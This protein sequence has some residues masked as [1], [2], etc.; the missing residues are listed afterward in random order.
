MI[1][2]P[3]TSTTSSNHTKQSFSPNSIAWGKQGEGDTLKRAQ[4]EAWTA[5]FTSQLE[6]FDYEIT[7]IEGTIPEGLRGSTLF[8]NGPSRFERGHQ[9]VSHYLD[10][11]GY[12]AKFAFSPEGRA[13]FKSRFVKTAE[14]QVEAQKNDL[15]FRTT[16]GN[17]KANTFWTHALDLYLKNPANTHVVPWGDRL[18]ALYEAGA[19]Y[20]LDPHTLETVG[21]ED[22]TGGVCSDPLPTSRVDGLMRRSQGQQAM[23]AHPHV[24]PVRDRIV[25]WTWG[26]SVQLHQPNSLIIE[27]TEYSPNWQPLSRTTHKM[28]GAAV[29]PH[30]FALTPNYY[31]FFENALSL[32]IWPYLLGQKA[33]AD[34]LTL[35]PRATKVHLIPRPD[36]TMADRAPLV[37]ETAQWFSIHQACAW[38]NDDGSVKVYSSGW[39]ATKG[40]F[41]TS[42]AGTAP[43]F[44]DIAPTFLWQTLIEPDSETLTHQLAPGVENCCIAHPHTSPNTETQPSRYLYMAHCNNIGESSPPTG[45]LKLDTQAHTAE[46]WNSHPLNFAE[47][48]IFVPDPHGTKEDDGWLLCLM[49]DHRQQR[50]ALN[51][52]DATDLTLGPICRLW[53]SHHLSH[54]LHGTWTPTYYA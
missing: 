7:E 11:D 46:R 40:G 4:V 2:R 45:Y 41:L 9:R 39:P 14:H 28:P 25:T 51:I 30:D 31:V 3:A 42:W 33:P 17:P 24:D 36:G 49:Y 10:G 52:F 38:E 34:C 48:P 43:N 32:D 54:G 53:L 47:E 23:T 35:E 29:N 19:P 50:S 8:R 13:Y 44:D 18:L 5:A 16:F 15:C 1:T 27:L 37:L 26:V 6:E 12:V 21:A 22:L 20:R